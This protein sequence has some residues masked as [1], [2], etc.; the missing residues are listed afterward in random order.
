MYTFPDSNSIKRTFLGKFH[1]DKAMYSWFATTLRNGHVGG[2][3]G[4]I[5]FQRIYPTVVMSAA[6][7]EFEYRK[8]TIVMF[9]S[10]PKLPIC[11]LH[12]FHNTP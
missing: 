8:Y 4:R 5:F 11:N 7:Q 12:M 2:P 10:I 1:N 6:N 9:Q 3:S